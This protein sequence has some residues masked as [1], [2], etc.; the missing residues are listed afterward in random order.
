MKAGTNADKT[1]DDVLQRVELQLY[2]DDIDG[3]LRL[4]E[5]ASDKTA[6]PRYSARAAT[7]RSWLAHLA[8]RDAYAAAYEEYYRE[9]KGR[10]CLKWLERDLR[11]LIGRKTKKTVARTATHEEFRLLEEEVLASDAARVLDAGCGEGRIAVT[12]AHRHPGIRVCAVEVSATN[13]GL[14]RRVNRYPNATFHQGLIEDFVEAAQP[15][16]FDLAYSFAVLEHVRDVD[17]VVAGILRVLRP[18]GRFCFVVP[19]N[20]LSAVAALPEF[21]PSDGVAGHVRLFTEPE[22]Q[23]RFGSLPDFRLVKLRGRWVPQRYPQGIV[24]EAFGSFFVAF[25][26]PP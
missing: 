13:V 12:L 26:K 11:I 24:P 3:A 6:D 21:T 5:A 25:S 10:L 22:L 18:G 14:A 23:A 4:L 16:T 7:I 20:G 9:R 19:M 2:R 8:T 17:E 1:P 15:G